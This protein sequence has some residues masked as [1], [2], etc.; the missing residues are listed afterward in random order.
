ML[1]NLDRRR[2]E[3]LYPIIDPTVREQVLD[4]IVVVNFND[5][6]QSWKV[7]PDG[8][9]T[10][11]KSP[12]KAR[13]FQR[14]QVLHDQSEPVGSW[15]I[16]Q[17]NQRRAASSDAKTGGKRPTAKGPAAKAR[18]RR[19]E[20]SEPGTRGVPEVLEKDL[21]THRNGAGPARSR[22]VRGRD[23]YR[24]ELGPPRGL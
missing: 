12:R 14:P 20:T 7:L 16:A 23:R 22:A 9:A 6:E 18:V 21:S 13:A 17:K 5:N 24:I 19:N 15:E 11:I 1:R 3:V 10:R 8:T 2:V 4:Q